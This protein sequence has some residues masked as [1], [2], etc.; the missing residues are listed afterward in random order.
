MFK[1]FK[2]KAKKMFSFDDFKNCKVAV[3]CET[4]DECEKFLEYC[5]KEGLKW[6][7][8][9]RAN[10]LNFF[11]ASKAIGMIDETIFFMEARLCHGEESGFRNQ[12]YEIFKCSDVLMDLAEPFKKKRNPLRRMILKPECLA[13]PETAICSS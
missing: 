1:F 8:G 10:K 2:R 12:G 6:A 7:T 11:D 4:K 3:V 13:L 9:E 5:D